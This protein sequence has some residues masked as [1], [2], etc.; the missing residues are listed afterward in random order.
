MDLRLSSPHQFSSVLRPDIQKDCTPFDPG[1]QAAGSTTK[2]LAKY[3]M[4]S[5]Q[6]LFYIVQA[7]SSCFAAFS[8]V[9]NIFYPMPTPPATSCPNRNTTTTTT[10]TYR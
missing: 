10:T 2:Y 1:Q 3:V 5:Q 7:C 6:D 4:E 9:H 8:A